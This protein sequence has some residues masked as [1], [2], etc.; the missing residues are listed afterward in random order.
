MPS[1]NAL[2]REE[3]E[4]GWKLLFNGKD[5]SGWRIRDSAAAPTGWVIRDSAL[6]YG[7][8]GPTSILSTEAYGDFE[9]TMEWK[10]GIGDDAGV[11]LRVWNEK[12]APSR[13][14]PEVQL[15]DNLFNTAG[16]EPKQSAGAC[17]NLYPP[18]FD[19]TSPLGQWNRL[20]VVANGKKVTHWLNDR[21]VVEYEIGSEDWKN[22]LARSTLKDYPDLGSGDRGFV[23]LQQ[24]SMS[25][26]FR[27]LKIRPLGMAIGVLAR[28]SKA[29]AGKR[30]AGI[31]GLAW[32]SS[33]DMGARDLQ[34]RAPALQVTGK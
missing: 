27:N 18:A 2:T 25:T 15:V 29:P 8:K 6:S 9:L 1:P 32:M 23:G 11:Y 10:V 34:G 26:R 3:E 5:L 33:G 22:R 7:G 31:R 14:S 12:S 19:A 17:N 30:G 16:M 4:T 21:K 24:V 20:K 13:V 28:G